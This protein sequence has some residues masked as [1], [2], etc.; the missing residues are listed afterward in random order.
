[1]KTKVIACDVYGTILATDDPEN[2]MP[3]RKGFLAFVA[4]CRKNGITIVTTSDNDLTLTKIDLEESGVCLSSFDHF[5]QMKR[6][7]PKNFQVV[8]DFFGIR[9]EQLLV[10]GDRSDLDISPAQ[11]IGC[12][13]KEVPEY[14]GYGDQFDWQEIKIT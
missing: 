1:M 3:P 14:E 7:L 13:V 12:Q 6:G 2:A 10:I 4:N 5:F 8:L 9:A 11:Q